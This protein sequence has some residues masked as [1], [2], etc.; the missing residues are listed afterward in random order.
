MLAALAW[1]VVTARR[2][3]VAVVDAVAFLSIAAVLA[4]VGGRA[5]A[6]LHWRVTQPSTFRWVLDP[7]EAGGYASAGAMLGA[8]VAAAV[9]YR[10]FKEQFWKIADV[11]TPA[12]FLALA[13]ARLGCV[14]ERCDPGRP[15]DSWG[16]IYAD[17]AQLHA[18]GAYIA[19]PM[20]LV[21]VLAH[22]AIHGRRAGLR[23]A[24]VLTSYGVIRFVAEFWRDAPTSLHAGHA[25]ACAVFVAGIALALR[26]RNGA[27]RG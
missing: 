11:V 12:G 21:V 6:L 7:L 23:A 5:W 15:T 24:F 18:F 25:I 13:F 22:V 19:L 16:V 26:R 27:L 20:M 4:V 10:V 14:V 3:R 1:T 9:A 8:T 2:D 17:G